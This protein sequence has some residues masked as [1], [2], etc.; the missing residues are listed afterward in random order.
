LLFFPN[1]RFRQDF[2]VG[3][4]SFSGLSGISS[5]NTGVSCINKGRCW[6]RLEVIFWRFV[7]FNEYFIYSNNTK[8]LRFEI[9]MEVAMEVKIVMLLCCYV[10]IFSR[11][12]QTVGLET[13]LVDNDDDDEDGESRGPTRTLYR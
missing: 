7:I 3:F 11:A 5:D 6:S 2:F 9:A 12:L 4:G 10:V 1:K 13:Y 8:G